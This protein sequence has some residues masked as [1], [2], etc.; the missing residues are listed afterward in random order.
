M[1]HIIQ[2]ALNVILVLKQSGRGRGYLKDWGGVVSLRAFCGS[3][4]ETER[5]T[6]KE[7]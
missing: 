1:E 7:E 2:L 6:T 4:Y 5:E 3:E